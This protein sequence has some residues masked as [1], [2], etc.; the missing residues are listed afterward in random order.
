[1]REAKD[2]GLVATMVPAVLR[3]RNLDHPDLEPFWAAARQIGMPIG[4]YTAPGIHL[5]PL[6]AD[7]FDNYLQV[8]CVSFPFDM[9]VA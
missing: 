8:H 6:G 3:T 7:R 9:M 4:I 5:P 2:L 1:M